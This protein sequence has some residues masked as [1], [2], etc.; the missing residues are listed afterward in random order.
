MAFKITSFWVFVGENNRDGTGDEGVPYFPTEEG[1]YRPLFGADEE[2]L[3]STR[4]VAQR[5]A[6]L[7]G[8][9]LRL[10]RFNQVSSEEIIK[11]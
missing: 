6:T 9:P 10:L 11:P 1:T 5:I 2:S 7:I 8:R 3:E 4:P